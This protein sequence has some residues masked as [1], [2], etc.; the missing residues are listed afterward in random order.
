MSQLPFGG[1]GESGNG[2]YHGKNSFDA[3]SHHKA[4]KSRK[5]ILEGANAIRY[6]PY[7]ERVRRLFMLIVEIEYFAIC[8]IAK[9]ADAIACLW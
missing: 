1:V 2:A 5:L 9:I 6:P 3:F 4:V 7:N 8:S